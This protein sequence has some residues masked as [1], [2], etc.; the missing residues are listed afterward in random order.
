[1]YQKKSEISIH[2]LTWNRWY[3]ATFAAAE[4][5]YD[6]L[7]QWDRIGSLTVDGVNQAF[8]KDFQSNIGTGT[9]A[10]GSSQYSALTGSIKSYADG[11]LSIAQ[12]YTPSDG[13]LAEQFSKSNGAPLSA[14]DLTWS[15]AAFLSA[16][17]R[18]NGKV[19]DSWLTN[20]ANNLPSQCQSSSQKGTY[21]SVTVSAWPT[22]GTSSPT[23]TQSGP[24]TTACPTAVAVTFNE[25][26]TT[27]YGESIFI[28]GSIPEL[29]SWSTDASNRIA[30]SADRYSTSNPVWYVSRSLPL[31]TSF[32]Y[33]YYKVGTDGRITWENDPNRS[34]TVPSN[35]QSQAAI[36]DS[37]R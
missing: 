32:Q 7:Y 13:A 28:T 23:T 37:W 3:L 15:Y 33:K 10:K 34:Y 2:L 29:G 12:K 26:V 11:F 19:P 8:F 24:S 16:Y 4:Q 6:A 35:C 21:S 9:Y 31:G 30:L 22:G 18:R 14:V 17:D 36:N 25:K 1:M 27:A 20:G 5:L